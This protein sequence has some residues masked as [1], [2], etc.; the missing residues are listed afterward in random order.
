[1]F[2]C[3]APA[4]NSGIIPMDKSISPPAAMFP[5]NMLAT[6][7]L[8]SKHKRHTILYQLLKLYSV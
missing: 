4:E 3:T 5:Q 8:N 2:L 6:G 1:M 7:L